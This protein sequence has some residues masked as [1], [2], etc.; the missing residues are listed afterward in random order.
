M[1]R[2]CNIVGMAQLGIDGAM[3]NLSGVGVNTTYD[4]TNK[5]SI[6]SDAV[7]FDHNGT[8]SRV[9]VNKNSSADTASHLFQSNYSGRAEFGLIANDD[10]QVKVSSDGSL[11]Y[12][13]FVVDKSS[14][15]IDFKQNI[16]LSGYVSCGDNLIIRPELKDYAE[17]LTIANSTTSYDIN[18]ESGNVFEITLTGN[19]IFTFSNA[20]ASG[21]GGKFTLILKQDATGSRTTTWPASAKWAGGMAPTLTTAAN[22]VDVLTFVT[23]SGGDIWYGR[24]DGVDVK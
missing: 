3:S 22:A 8:D 9:K 12:Q 6:K 15:N 14:G 21:K 19:C 11:W 13:S 20:P 2:I 5:L 23:T 18:L 17:T 1:T 10:F 4:T 24:A 7:L 16:A